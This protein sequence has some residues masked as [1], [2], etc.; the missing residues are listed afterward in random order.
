MEQAFAHYRKAL[1]LDPEHKGAHEY[2]GEAY[3][4]VGD[5]ARAEEHLAALDGLCFFGCE[6]YR[7]LKEAIAAYKAKQSS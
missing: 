3:L 4:M 7:E 1:D 6:E 2:I 5:L